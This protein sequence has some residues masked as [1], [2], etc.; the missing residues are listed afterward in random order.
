DVEP[1]HRLIN[2]RAA[3][4]FD[5]QIAAGFVGLAYPVGLSKLVGELIGAR[6]GKGLTFT[7]WDQ[8]P[9]SPAQLRYA[10]DDVRYLPAL[11]VEIKRRLSS[12]GHESWAREECDSLC[13]PSRYGFDPV[14]TWSR[15]RGSGS[16]SPAQLAVLRELTIW[17]DAGARAHDVPARSFLKD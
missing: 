10:A 13:E 15:I 9:L 1:V 6:L 5:T 7:H 8:R 17:R 14:T 2:R 4:I 3:N 16:L 11:H 12:L